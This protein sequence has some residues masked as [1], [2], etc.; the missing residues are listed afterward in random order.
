[1]LQKPLHSTKKENRCRCCRSHYTGL[2]KTKWCR[3]CSSHYSGYKYKKFDADALSITHSKTQHV[4][5]AVSID[6]HADCMP[7][8][9]F[10]LT[11]Y[12]HFKISSCQKRERCV[13]RHINNNVDASL[14]IAKCRIC[15]LMNHT[16]DSHTFAL[17]PLIDQLHQDIWK[18]EFRCMYCQTSK[19][20]W[21]CQALTWR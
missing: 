5:L 7:W 16:S 10:R 12:D 9:S 18:Q 14:N 13:S 15:R 20:T 2:R 4:S 1:M 11:A 21:K 3:C 6:W 8:K 17:L 19:T